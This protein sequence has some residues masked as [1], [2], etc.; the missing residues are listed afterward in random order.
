MKLLEESEK[1]EN[2]EIKERNNNLQG[3]LKFQMQHKKSKAEDGFIKEQENAYKTKVI[4]E[5]EEDEFLKYAESWVHEY[6]S[7]GKDINPLMLELKRFK[8]KNV[9]G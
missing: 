5:K 7:S 3:F 9:F 4:L 1:L 8:K 2:D 6:H